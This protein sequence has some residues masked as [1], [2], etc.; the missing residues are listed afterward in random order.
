MLE[1]A[2]DRSYPPAWRIILAFLVAPA[3]ASLFLAALAP[4]YGGLSSTVVRVIQTAELY[5]LL[6][7]YPTTLVIGVP[8]YF[9]LRRHFSP[10]PFNCAVAGALVAA[11]P[12]IILSLIPSG[13]GSASI[14]G[15]ETIA[16]GHLT[17]YG[18][19]A[20]AW[21]VVQIAIA[22]WLAGVIFWAIA[23]AGHRAHDATETPN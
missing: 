7:A 16:D 2:P 11:L 12:W 4:L 5:A 9:I 6:G 23:A 3:A 8:A 1:D 20:Q 10:R 14:G 18:W 13:A 17:G 22:G 19:L 21:V 15:R